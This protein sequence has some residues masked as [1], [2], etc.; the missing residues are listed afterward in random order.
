MSRKLNK[1]GIIV[2]IM[3]LSIGFA[4]VTA[5]LLINSSANV[6]A[7]LADFDVHF[8]SAKASSG[9]TARISDDKKSITF[10]GK[11][12]T[13][14]GDKVQLSYTVE[15]ES[16]LYDANVSVTYNIVDSSGIDHSEYYNIETTGFNH[17]DS[18]AVASKGSKD[19]SFTI[20]LT[21]AYLGEPFVLEVEVLLDVTAGERTIRGNYEVVSG[22]AYDSDGNVLANTPLVIFS[23]P[24][25]FETDD[26]GRFELTLPIG[27]H[28]SY[29]IP[30]ATI[31]EL[32]ELGEDI[33]LDSTASFAHLEVGSY[34]SDLVF[35]INN[36]GDEFRINGQDFYLIST[37]YDGYMKLLA[38]K[39]IDINTLKQ[40]D[41]P[42]LVNYSSDIE[43]DSSSD[44]IADK[45][46][47]LYYKTFPATNTYEIID[48]ELLQLYD[49]AGLIDHD[50]YN[51]WELEDNLDT[52]L[53]DERRWLNGN[54]WLGDS[55][56]DTCEID[57]EEYYCGYAFYI[58]NNWLDKGL[59]T[60]E[61]HYVR[62]VIHLKRKMG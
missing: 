30:G 37:A 17:G 35:L 59:F 2:L 62:P 61:S 39:P 21:K 5:N 58:S 3:I 15:N 24:T 42:T 22:I 41:S 32:E 7:N 13:K 53:Y 43:S 49:L 1:I 44:S 48:G 12:L 36:V 56:Y 27:K 18:V 6:S 33:Q 29:Y 50:A 11:Q 16:S 19:G 34:D 8:S 51:L 47:M 10:T 4:A 38:K 46:A 14:V 54:Y 57:D 31:D 26:E 55:A 25:Y 23:E 9:S 52:D 40:S 45:Y 28:T 60:Q 20:T